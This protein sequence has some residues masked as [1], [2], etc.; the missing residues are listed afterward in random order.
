MIFIV[1]LILMSTTVLLLSNHDTQAKAATTKTYQKRVAKLNWKHP[2]YLI[3]MS[4]SYVPRPAN[5]DGLNYLLQGYSSKLTRIKTT[6][7]N[8]R[9]R[10]YITKKDFLTVKAHS[11]VPTKYDRKMKINGPTNYKKIRLYSLFNSSRYLTYKHGKDKPAKVYRAKTYYPG[12]GRY[13]DIGQTSDV[14]RFNVKTRSGKVIPAVL[15]ENNKSINDEGDGKSSCFGTIFYHKYHKSLPKII[16]QAYNQDDFGYWPNSVSVNAL[17][18]KTVS[19]SA[20]EANNRQYKK[21]QCKDPLQALISEKVRSGGGS[22]ALQYLTKVQ[23]YKLTSDAKNYYS[24][25]GN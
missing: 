10:W 5:D 6:P 4:Y 8:I 13:G 3:T 24:G 19:A 12:M 7:K 17:N 1:S 21:Y 16:Y 22:Q 11:F 15:S 25:L 2:Y 18:G 14:Q 23:K 9:G 20:I